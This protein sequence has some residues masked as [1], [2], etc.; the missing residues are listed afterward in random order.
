MSSRLLGFRS[1]LPIS[2]LSTVPD[3]LPRSS[4]LVDDRRTPLHELA[5]DVIVKA[6]KS[7]SRTIPRSRR[8]AQYTLDRG[9]DEG[10]SR[11][12]GRSNGCIAYLDGFSL[13]TRGVRHAS[14]AI[15]HSSVCNAGCSGVAVTLWMRGVLLRTPSPVERMLFTLD[16]GCVKPRL[17]PMFTLWMRGVP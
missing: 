10:T 1:S 9:W 3:P 7:L 11:R 8:F 15:L 12:S 5:P 17:R 6:A 2:C 14:D 4:V 13:W 16:E